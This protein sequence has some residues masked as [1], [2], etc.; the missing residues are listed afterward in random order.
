MFL[1]ERYK[2]DYDTTSCNQIKVL[3]MIKVKIFRVMGVAG[4]IWSSMALNAHGIYARSEGGLSKPLNNVTKKAQ[5]QY[6]NDL[7]G[8]WEGAYTCPQGPTN[9][10]LV[11]TAKSTKNIDAVF[12]FSPHP[13]NPN[14]PSGSFRM[15]GNLER[16][17]LLYLKATTWINK[18]AGYMTVDLRGNIYTSRSRI[19]GNILSDD[20]SA[21][22]LKRK[23]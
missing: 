14:T 8:T 15:K 20:C 16:P 4:L 1:C 6:L 3:L 13:N 11:I 19:I 5:V 18:P 12:Q 23:E 9:L 21:F 10:K 2:I 17:D 22:E 7:N